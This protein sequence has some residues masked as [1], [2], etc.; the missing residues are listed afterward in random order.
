[1]EDERWPISETFILSLCFT[2]ISY[3]FSHFLL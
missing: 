3:A 2:M 1:L